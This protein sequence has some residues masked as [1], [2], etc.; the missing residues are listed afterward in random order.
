MKNVEKKV[1]NV[2]EWSN[3]SSNFASGCVNDCLY[4]YSR[5]MAIRFKRK[6]TDT[7]C[8]EEINLSKVNKK[9]KK[10]EG[11]IMF[12][13]SHDISLT[14]IDFAIIHLRN[15]LEVGN[16]VLIVSKPKIEVIKRLCEELYEYKGQILFRFSIGSTNSDTLRFWERSGS[17]YDERKKCLIYAFNNGFS[18]SVS[19]EPLLDTNAVEL[20]NDLVPYITDA[21]W[22][23]K[24]NSL[25]RRLKINGFIDD[26][27]M[28]RAKDLL[29]SQSE[30]Y[31]I[32]LCNQL[33]KN[34]MIKWKGD[35]K[36]IAGLEIPTK[37][38]LDI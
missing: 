33:S 20:V 31:F 32:N 28:K 26:E 30:T 7:W 19:A 35:L 5:E 13:S 25:Y 29:A 17:N 12:P 11:R 37:I 3:S 14:N 23:G 10:I 16:Q 4:C 9:F 21:I 1:Q 8:N 2:F 36:L 27:T 24:I 22:I 18:T 6:T 38:G 15:M 34:P